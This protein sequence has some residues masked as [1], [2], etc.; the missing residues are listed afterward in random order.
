MVKNYLKL[1]LLL[2]PQKR[3]GG[4]RPTSELP[5]L[6]YG[7]VADA[8]GLPCARDRRLSWLKRID[9]K[10]CGSSPIKTKEL[11]YLE[12]ADIGTSRVKTIMHQIQGLLT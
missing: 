10:S 11:S 9:D 8:G 2:Q 12:S 4:W 7:P 1:Q 3:K 6:I 5:A